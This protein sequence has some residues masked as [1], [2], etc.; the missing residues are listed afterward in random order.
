MNLLWDIVLRA[1][2]QGLKEEDLFFAQAKEFSPFFEQSFPCLNEQHISSNRIELNLFFRLADLFQDL[3]SQELEE[4]LSRAEDGYAEFREYL[5]DACLHTI[6]YGDLRDGLTKRE[7]FI[8][9]LT[10]ELAKG[11]F[12]MAAAGDFQLIDPHKQMRLATLTLTQMQTGSSLSIYR[13]A[14]LVLFPDARLYQMKADKKK[15]LL[16]LG[17][18]RTEEYQR[19][20]GFVQDLFLPMSYQIRIFWEHHF[21]IIGA[22][23]TMK[24]GEI[25][26]Y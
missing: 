15:L 25:A 17:Q 6:L 4:K 8:R 2:D 20:M 3:L 18:R 12:W 19:M 13:R 11:D 22:K 9:E 1:Q 10:K 5:I 23:A 26:L 14:I 7:V 16:Y 21:G 24:I